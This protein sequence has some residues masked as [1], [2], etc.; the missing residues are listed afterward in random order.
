MD[1][2]K[3]LYKNRDISKVKKTFKNEGFIIFKKIAKSQDIENVFTKR[4][5]F[6]LASKDFV[7]KRINWNSKDE[8]IV[9]I[10]KEL[11]VGLDSLVFLDDSSFEIGN[12]E[13]RVPDVVCFCVPSNLSEYPALFDELEK[14]F[15]TV[16]SS[17]EDLKRSDMYRDEAF[18]RTQKA[19]F[20]SQMDYIRSLD[21]KIKV[22]CNKMVNVARASQLTQKTNQF[23]L[24]TKRYS[25]PDITAMIMSDKFF[26]VSFSVQDKYGDYG[27]T[28][29][30]ILERGAAKERIIIDT[31]LMSCRIIG[32][33][34]EI[35]IVDYL[36]KFLREEGFSILEA[37][38][39][40]T[41]K[42]MQTMNFFDSMGFTCTEPHSE[43]KNYIIKFEDYKKM[44][45]LNIKIKEM[46]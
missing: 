19:S 6:A 37:K 24:T 15:F 7:A 3:F 14:M 5:D 38:Y 4:S 21:L 31:F 22:S 1:N 17:T 34:I 26:L 33:K 28:G 23:N 36:I 39:L 27:T 8:N 9:E 44:D 20:A 25:E 10:A 35:A 43:Q 11:N 41:S 2:K 13:A 46:N 32:R 30:V 18:R 42:N 29:L 40:R 16:N 45:K 12:I